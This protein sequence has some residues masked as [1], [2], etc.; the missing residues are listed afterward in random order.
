M[1]TLNQDLTIVFLGACPPEEGV[2]RCRRRLGGRVKG[3]TLYV[4]DSPARAQT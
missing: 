1:T 3:D 2:V 4:H